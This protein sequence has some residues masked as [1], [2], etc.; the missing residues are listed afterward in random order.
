M[1]QQ[2]QQSSYQ[3][4]YAQYPQEWPAQNQYQDPRQAF[5]PPPQSTSFVDPRYPQYSQQQSQ[6]FSQQ[7]PHPQQLQRASYPPP[8]NFPQN[9]QLQSSAPHQ[10][11]NGAPARQDPIEIVQVPDVA[12]PPPPPPPP[13]PIVEAP[14][15]P[16]PVTPTEIY[17]RIVQVG[18]GTYGKVYKAKN[19]ETGVLVALKRIRM[20]AE[21]DGFPVTAIR[22]IKLLQSLRHPNVVDLI[23]MMISRGQSFACLHDEGD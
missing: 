18:E 5:P 20:E 22:E 8:S 9:G 1:Q 15:E 16:V 19:L 11:S 2:Q 17:E 4:Q 23:E 14:V 6:Q 10:Q 7:P 12:P 13:P 21:K 3:A